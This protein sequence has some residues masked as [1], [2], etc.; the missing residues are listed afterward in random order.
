MFIFLVNV[1]LGGLVNVYVIE[2][3]GL[4]VVLFLVKIIEGLVNVEIE[5]LV[6]EV[7]FILLVVVYIIW[8]VVLV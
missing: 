1:K 4:V 8:I 7:V 6:F 5:F 2:I 3:L